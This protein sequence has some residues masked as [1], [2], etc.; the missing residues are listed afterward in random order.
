MQKRFD[1]LMRLQRDTGS[2]SQK[3]TDNQ[4]TPVAPVRQSS[5]YNGPGGGAQ[6]FQ[7]G[8]TRVDPLTRSTPPSS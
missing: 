3:A 6:R 7:G 8:S 2:M 1:D 4:P 5:G